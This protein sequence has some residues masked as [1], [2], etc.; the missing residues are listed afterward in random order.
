MMASEQNHAPPAPSDLENPGAREEV[1]VSST[2]RTILF[3]DPADESAAE[4][5]ESPE[6]FHDL[7][8]DQIVDAVVARRP[9]YDLKPFFHAPLTREAAI[10][11][12]HEVMRDLGDEALF[13]RVKS[14]SGRMRTMREHLAAADN[15]N[16]KYQKEWWFVDAAETYGDAV[17]NLL[18]DL[19][20]RDVQSRGLRSFRDYLEHYAA[21]GRCRALVQDA[22]KLKS[23]LAA[24]RYCVLI[25]DSSV[26]V[27]PYENEPDYTAA[28]E[29]TF[30]K[31]RQADAKD[32]RANLPSA[33][34][35][36]VEAMILERVAQLHPEVFSSLLE[37]RARHDGFADP[38]IVRFDREIQFYLAWLEHAAVLER[39]GLKFCFPLVSATNKDVLSRDGFDLGL[40]DKLVREKGR[41]VTND[42]FLRGAER[43]FV[44]TGPNQGGKT[45]F[46]RTFGQLHYLASLGVT[47]PG[48][49]ARLFPCDRIH[50]HFERAEDIAN[51]R[52]KLEDDLVR[53]HRILDQ[54]TSNSIVIINEILSSTTLQDA[55]ALGGKI[56]ARITQLDLLCVCVTFLDEL[57]AL[58]EKVVSMVAAV[59]ADDPTRRTFKIERRPANGLSYAMAIAEKY[60]LTRER[61]KERLHRRE[62]LGEAFPPVP[63]GDGSMPRPPPEQSPSTP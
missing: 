41:V 37:F 7:G 49:E 24:I 62:R 33:A 31:F 17:E 16:Y 40:A 46:A 14:F 61:L 23:D 28:V 48:T 29:E 44:V 11:F 47:V 21:S 56:L 27:R 39:A 55:V 59:A 18:R 51:H 50:T 10:A 1:V 54:A 32:Y 3:A 15:L 5:H 13:E 58:N 25:R 2:F 45:T 8:L 4:L 38:T 42:F 52:G 43:I 30:A 12:R 22:R 6:F 26:T 63:G 57:A 35:N 53:I 19:R 34:M 20:E 60:R 9:D 36:H